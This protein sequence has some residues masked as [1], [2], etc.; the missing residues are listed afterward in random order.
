MGKVVR[1]DHSQY[2]WA[3]LELVSLRGGGGDEEEL[4]KRVRG[5]EAASMENI[6]LRQM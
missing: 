2:R 4:L 5:W 6:K 3:Y 1:G